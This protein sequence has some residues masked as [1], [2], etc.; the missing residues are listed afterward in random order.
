MPSSNDSFY[1]QKIIGTRGRNKGDALTNSGYV[2]YNFSQTDT[3]LNLPAYLELDKNGKYRAQDLKLR[4]AVPEG[5]HI[6]FAD[7]I[8]R[9]HATV[10]GDGS[11]DDTYFANTTWTTKNGKVVCVK[12]ENHSN[13]EE[14]DKFE[15]TSVQADSAHHKTGGININIPTKKKKSSEKDDK[16]Q[17]F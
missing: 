15:I 7:N 1:V 17:D 13:G 8:D 10:K 6:R 2:I 16:D 3:V 11:F 14:E 12:G 4:I 5:K 9:W